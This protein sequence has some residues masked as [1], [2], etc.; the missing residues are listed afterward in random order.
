MLRISEMLGI[1][2]GEIIAIGDSDN[3]ASMLRASGMP[4][5]M[6]NADDE[7]KKLAKYITSGCD[8]DGAARAIYHLC[9]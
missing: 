6:G 2:A 5:A 4:V 1:P 3:D 7:L 8:H 9:I